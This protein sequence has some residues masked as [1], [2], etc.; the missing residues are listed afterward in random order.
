[1][2][3]KECGAQI[4]NPKAVICVQCGASLVDAPQSAQSYNGVLS[5]IVP[6]NRPVSAIFAGYLGLFSLF[7]SPLGII[8][9][10][11]GIVALGTLKKHPEMLGRGRAWFGIIAGAIGTVVLLVIL[12]AGCCS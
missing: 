11:V 5:A 2:F 3:C 6:I 10:I 1:M 7:I 8:A 4:A 12:I 9:I